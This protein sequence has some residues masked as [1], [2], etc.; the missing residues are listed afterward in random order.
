MTKKQKRFS[1]AELLK[2][3]PELAGEN[4]NLILAGGQVYNLKIMALEKQE[5]VALDGLRRI[6]RFPVQ[7]IAEI[8]AEKH[9]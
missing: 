3:L 2:V 8:I 5:L 6:H 9:A 7:A 4:I 1:Q